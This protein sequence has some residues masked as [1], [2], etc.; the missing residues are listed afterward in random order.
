M[1]VVFVGGLELGDSGVAGAVAGGDV[2]YG[3]G[4]E[5]LDDS[6]Y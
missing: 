4:L 6:I 3:D 2:G 1:E 5:F